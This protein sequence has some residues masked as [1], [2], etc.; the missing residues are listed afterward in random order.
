MATTLGEQVAALSRM[1]LFRSVPPKYL[2]I[3]VKQVKLRRYQEG[4]Q[5]FLQGDDADRAMLVVEGRLV[6]TVG[7]KVVGEVSVGEV[8]GETALFVRGGKRSATVTAKEP[9]RCL[10]ITRDLL[11]SSAD[12]PAVVAI[13]RHLLG[14]LARR[15]RSTNLSIQRVWKEDAPTDGPSGPGAAAPSVRERLRGLFG[16]SR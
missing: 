16:R 6:S 4:Q 9:T 2:K 1:Y 3:F 11:A 5:V 14:S 10:V 13:E 15:I 8:V 12:N 7:D